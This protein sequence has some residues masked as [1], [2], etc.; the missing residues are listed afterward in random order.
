MKVSHHITISGSRSRA[1]A[2]FVYLLL[3]P[4]RSAAHPGHALTKISRDA[5]EKRRYHSEQAKRYYIFVNY[6]KILIFFQQ[7]QVDNAFYFKYNK[8]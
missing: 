1:A 4:I 8:L 5:D 7:K 2:F 6:Y 3:Q